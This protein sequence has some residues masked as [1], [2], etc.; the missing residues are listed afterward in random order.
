MQSQIVDDRMRAYYHQRAPE[1][2]DRWLG[3]GLFARRERPG[4]PVEVDALI[5]LIGSLQPARVL[6]VACGTGF[7]TQHLRGDVVAIDQSDAMVS[8][9]G[10]RMPHARVLR[11]DAMPLPFA[12]GE[13][14]RV[15]TSHFYGHLLTRGCGRPADA[16]RGHRSRTP[17][18]HVR[19][20][21]LAGG[22]A[23]AP[24]VVTAAGRAY[25]TAAA[26]RLW[27]ISAQLTGV[28]FDFHAPDPA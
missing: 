4:W 2:D 27:E 8:V 13:F 28:Q 20:S 23:R 1:Y 16:V 14:D 10:A 26:G 18:G 25:D 19:R 3:T 5:R 21:R 6:D 9:A 24:A 17:R 15:F 22:A 12:D 11:A 7:Q